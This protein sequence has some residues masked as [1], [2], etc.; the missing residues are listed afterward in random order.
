MLSMFG[1]AV[2][3]LIGIKLFQSAIIGQ[4][5]RIQRYNRDFTE[6]YKKKTLRRSASKRNPIADFSQ[7]L[8][9][10]KEKEKLERHQEV[11]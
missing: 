7:S 5:Y 8:E 3:Y 9:P 1:K 6:F 4:V 10:E 2:T 11:L